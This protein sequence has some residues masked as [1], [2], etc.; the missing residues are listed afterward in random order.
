MRWIQRE[1]KSALRALRSRYAYCSPFSTRSRAML[2]QLLARPRKPV[3]QARI[4]LA[5]VMGRAR[6]RRRRAGG[7]AGRGAAAAGGAAPGA[8]GS[9]GVGKGGVSGA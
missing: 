7:G 1:R 4:F 2:M 8:A 5:P 9:R 6:E 3:A